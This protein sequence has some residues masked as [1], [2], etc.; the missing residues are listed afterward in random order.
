MET[1]SHESALVE[2]I[3]KLPG[4]EKVTPDRDARE[5]RVEGDTTEEAIQRARRDADLDKA[6]L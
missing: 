4:V 5:L 6:G 2:A 1:E 3:E